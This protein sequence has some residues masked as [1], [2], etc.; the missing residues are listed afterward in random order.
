MSRA[1]TCVMLHFLEILWRRV[2]AVKEGG[3][4]VQRSTHLMEHV[5]DEGALCLGFFLH[6]TITSQ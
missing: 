5:S 3:E 1:R 2:V 4:Y 6:D